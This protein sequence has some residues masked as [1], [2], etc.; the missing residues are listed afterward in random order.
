[1]PAGYPA[2]SH[3]PSHDRASGSPADVVPGRQA[4]RR[5]HAPRRAVWRPR[6]RTSEFPAAVDREGLAG[7]V[8]RLTRCQEYDGVCDIARVAE[9]SE[10]D[11]RNDRLFRLVRYLAAD[12]VGELAAGEPAGPHRI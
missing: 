8:T 11:R 12:P 4:P 3:R 6:S 10:R 9:S 5:P 7:D 1:M 2:T